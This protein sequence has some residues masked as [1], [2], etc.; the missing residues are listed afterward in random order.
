MYRIVLAV[1]SGE[2]MRNDPKLI[3]GRIY[4]RQYPEKYRE[5]GRP[6]FLVS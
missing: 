6:Y 1:V 3:V 2:A 5:W 4:S